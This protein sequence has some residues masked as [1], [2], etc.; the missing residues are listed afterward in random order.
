MFYVISVSY[1]GPNDRDSRGNFLGD[2]E[3][4]SITTEAPRTNMSREIRVNGWLGTTNDWSHYAH[5]EFEVYEDALGY[6][7]NEGFTED[8]EENK[9]DVLGTWQRKSATLEKWDAGNWLINA[10]GQDGVLREYGISSETTDEEIKVLVERIK[11][12]AEND[13]IAL[14]GTKKCLVRLRDELIED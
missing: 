1:T 9:A 2:T 14:F 10:M 12:E 8:V 3:T 4:M 13:G 11:E 5:G 7:K 6:V